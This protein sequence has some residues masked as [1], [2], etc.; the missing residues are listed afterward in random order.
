MSYKEGIHSTVTHDGNT[1]Y[2]DDVI[3]LAKHERTQ[4]I[5]VKDLF[6]LL[7]LN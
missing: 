4:L 5:E 7:L 6:W 3:N 1:Y 2:V